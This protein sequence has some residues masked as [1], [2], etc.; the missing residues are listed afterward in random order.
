[1][2]YLI[3]SRVNGKV[4]RKGVGLKRELLVLTRN[5]KKTMIMSMNRR[6]K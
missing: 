3:G 4:Q 6:M 2:K 1:M 5:G